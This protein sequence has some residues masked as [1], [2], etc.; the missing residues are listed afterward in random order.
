[1][2][3]KIFSIEEVNEWKIPPFQRP[4][5]T[6]A[7]VL[8]LAEVMRQ[9]GGSIPGV[10]TLGHIAN[11]K[12]VW[13]VDGQHR[14]EAFKLSGL[15]EC[16]ADVRMCSFDSMA[17]MAEEFVGLN[18]ALVKMRPDDILRGL[19][20]SNAA[21][22]FI[23][24]HCEFVGY[25]QIRRNSSTAP[26]VSMSALLRCWASSAGET[27]GGA[28]RQIPAH[29]HAASLDRLAAEKLVVFLQVA[30]AAWG[31]DVEYARL[32]GALNL[33]ICMWLWRRLVLEEERGVKRFVRLTPEQFKKCLMSVSASSD[34]NDWLRGRV[35]G[36]R[37]RSPCYARLK[38][39]FVARLQDESRDKKKP[40]MPLPAWASK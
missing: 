31:G 7:K 39:I 8:S 3:T 15:P 11:D 40:M 16:I 18:S 32:W 27:P 9:E 14:A 25:D 17:E 20:G 23:R 21:L 35:M 5:R 1:M 10:V 37:D 13:L 36:D 30:R 38:A 29:V 2:D 4:L 34:Y 12:T 6:N 26:A 28:Q 33:T 22:K 24:E 19:E